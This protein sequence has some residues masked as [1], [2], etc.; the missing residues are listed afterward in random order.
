MFL[1]RKMFCQEGK[2]F[3]EV[4]YVLSGKIMFATKITFLRGEMF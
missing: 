3:F 4:E 1:R 2:E